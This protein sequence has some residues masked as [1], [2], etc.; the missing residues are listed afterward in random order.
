[1]SG[2]ASNFIDGA[3]CLAA[4]VPEVDGIDSFFPSL[5]LFLVDP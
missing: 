2:P 5:L 3:P 4:G 1:V